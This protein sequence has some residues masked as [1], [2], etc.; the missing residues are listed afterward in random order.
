MAPEC[1]S[2]ETGAGVV[3][4]TITSTGICYFSAGTV[5]CDA[6][7]YYSKRICCCQSSGCSIP[8]VV[9][10]TSPS[11]TKQPTTPVTDDTTAQ[12]ISTVASSADNNVSTSNTT[13]IV[14]LVLFVIIVLSLVA[15]VL[16]VR[17]RRSTQKLTPDTTPQDPAYQNA[18][19]IDSTPLVKSPAFQREPEIPQGEPVYNDLDDFDYL[20]PTE[21]SKTRAPAHRHY[22]SSASPAS[23]P[24]GTLQLTKPVGELEPLPNPLTSEPSYSVPRAPRPRDDPEIPELFPRARIN[25][26]NPALYSV[27]ADMP[28]T[29]A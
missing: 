5:T 2:F 14:V 11:S 3:D 10:T 17:S 25:T 15:V 8:G 18:N 23:N 9:T 4:P 27:G 24:L 22:Y 16:Y 13:M 19:V 7:D 1:K 12:T 29:A 26:W 6:L 28:D 20:E 21:S